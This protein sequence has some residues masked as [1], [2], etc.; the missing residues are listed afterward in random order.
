M[1]TI[2][3]VLLVLVLG[4]GCGGSKEKITPKAEP[5]IEAKKTEP[6]KATPEKFIADPIVEEAIRESLKKPTDELTKEDLEKVTELDLEGNKLTKVPKGLEKLTKLMWLPLSDN[7][8]LTNPQIAE[9]KKA[10]PK[11][12]IISDPTK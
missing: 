9:L 10:L 12:K 4:V 2:Y 1:K 11:C 7:P 8:D 5:K 6:P 3:A